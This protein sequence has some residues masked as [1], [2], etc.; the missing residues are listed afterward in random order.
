MFSGIVTVSR[1]E[2]AAFLP[3]NESGGQA[4]AAKGSKLTGAELQMR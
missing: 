4:F 2:F 1:Y 3:R